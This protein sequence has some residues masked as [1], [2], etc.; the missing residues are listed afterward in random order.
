MSLPDQ[1]GNFDF[2]S[3]WYH[4]RYECPGTV[5]CIRDR[6]K[7]LF[8]PPEA[9]VIGEAYPSGVCYY[10]FF[11]P[12][13]CFPQ[14]VFL[15]FALYVNAIVQ[16]CS[17]CWPDCSSRT[18]GLGISWFVRWILCCQC[19]YLCSH[20]CSLH[21]ALCL[22]KGPLAWLQLWNSLWCWKRHQDD[23]SHGW[24]W[25]SCCNKEGVM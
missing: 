16:T 10:F 3:R 2:S 24:W 6:L 14:L 21:T 12:S 23:P 9:S 22:W 11:F 8:I 4:L 18:S 19:G 7:A 13:D 20:L 25:C 15:G 5:A 17:M 1:L